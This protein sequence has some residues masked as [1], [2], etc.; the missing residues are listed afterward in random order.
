MTVRSERTGGAAAAAAAA[1]GEE[2]EE[3]VSPLVSG[4]TR[5]IEDEAEK[6]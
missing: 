6:Q 4:W 3:K 5:A 2:E 1:T